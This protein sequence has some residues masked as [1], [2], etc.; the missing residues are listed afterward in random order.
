MWAAHW[1][2]Q[3]AYERKVPSTSD[4]LPSPHRKM[5]MT[6]CQ[7]LTI[8]ATTYII[9]IPAGRSCWKAEG[10]ISGSYQLSSREQKFISYWL[11]GPQ[12]EWVCSPPPSFYV[13]LLSHFFFFFSNRTDDRPEVQKKLSA[14]LK[15]HQIQGQSRARLLNSCILVCQTEPLLLQSMYASELTCYLPKNR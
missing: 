5:W 8:L 13:F 11:V 3:R 6:V 14:V 4:I 7:S 12:R 1:W 9:L 15:A 2:E 10:M